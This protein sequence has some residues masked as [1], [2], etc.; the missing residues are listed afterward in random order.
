MK[1]QRFAV[2]GNP[3]AHSLSP[4]IHQRF[5]EQFD[6]QIDYQKHKLEPCHVNQWVMNFFEN[7][8][9]GLNV[10]LP[11]KT[12]AF[13]LAKIR[14]DEAAKAQA[15]N[16]LWFS[17]GEL[18][19]DN[20]DGRGLVHDLKRHLV[21]K[22]MNI[23]ILGA[24]GAAKGIIP[25][26]LLEKPRTLTV[27]NR[28]LS[29]AYD[30][31][32]QFKDVEIANI[33]ALKGVFDL[34]INATSTGLNGELIE[35]TQALWENAPFCYDLVYS[36]EKTTPF[37]EKARAHHCQ[38]QDGLG[39]LVEQAAESYSIWQGIKPDVD[40]VLITLKKSLNN[41]A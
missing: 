12:K 36:L 22:D 15:V 30:L 24:G 3:I 8:G 28:T 1:Y 38:A 33:D 29:K 4:V 31:Q 23:L 35:L 37:V 10:T 39:M 7:G 18:Y 41:R 20:T 13:E 19:G 16:T 40:S 17:N 34:I 26:L 14:T 11:F 25:A 27:A 5:A 2:I 32:H 21:L 6:H 9:S